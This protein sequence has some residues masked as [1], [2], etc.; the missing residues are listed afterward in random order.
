MIHIVNGP[1][2]VSYLMTS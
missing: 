1:V 2:E